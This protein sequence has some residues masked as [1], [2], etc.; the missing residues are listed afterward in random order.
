MLDFIKDIKNYDELKYYNEITKL[1]EAIG[2]RSWNLYDKQR[3]FLILGF[4]FSL[5]GF[6][7]YIF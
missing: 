4:I 2:K 6:V 5:I 7:I 1:T 3:Y